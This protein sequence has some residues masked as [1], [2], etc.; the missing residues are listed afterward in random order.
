MKALPEVVNGSFYRSPS[1]IVEKRKDALPCVPFQSITKN[2]RR[3]SVSSQQSGDEMRCFER[4]R[5]VPPV[6]HRKGREEPDSTNNKQGT[7]NEKQRTKNPGALDTT[8]LRR[9]LD[10]LEL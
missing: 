6:P 10:H 8:S 1:I 7:K 3:S 5:E 9:S 2:I 4:S